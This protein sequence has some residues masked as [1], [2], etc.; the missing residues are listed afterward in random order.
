MSA[1]TT[2]HRLL[3]PIAGLCV[4]ASLGSCRSGE[5]VANGASHAPQTASERRIVSLSPALT[6]LLFAL[7]AG[8]EVVGVTRYCD[9]P[10]EVRSLPQVGGY[11]DPSAEAIV[12]LRPTLVVAAPSPGNRRNV[13]AVRGLGIEV[14]VVQD[15]RLADLDSSIELLGRRLG[16]SAEAG[17][18]R[19]RLAA[20][21]DAVQ[22]RAV[23]RPPVRVL[24][25]YGHRPLVV[26]CPSSFGGELLRLIG[27]RNICTGD[28]PYPAFSMER[29]LTSRP[30]VILEAGMEGAAG[31]PG[32]W[33]RWPS[34]PAVATG[35]IR[36]L[37]ERMQRPGPRLVEALSELEA[38]IYGTGEGTP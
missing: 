18:L 32:F 27:A 13:E 33:A 4:L 29:V 12:A 11:L 25:V 31:G 22:A 6:E 2:R 38:A 30:E 15:R 10:P 9:F 37:S 24:L 17:R 8:D 28:D 21:F 1:R 14:L 19:A 26:G 35:R 34:L 23:G 3:L 36:R 20:G 16:R 5:P 7:G